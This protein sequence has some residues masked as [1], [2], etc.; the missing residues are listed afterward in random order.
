MVAAW[1]R[2]LTG[3]GPSIASGSHTWSGNCALLP[4]APPKIRRA[5][6]AICHGWI[7]RPRTGL[8]SFWKTSGKLSV[9]TVVQMA[10]IPSAKPRSPTRLTMK[11]FLAAS[12]AERR[13]YQKPISR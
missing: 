3:V 7:W 4:M 10:M 12:A 11:A 6:P 2:A 13:R 5:I 1:M 8:G 9:P